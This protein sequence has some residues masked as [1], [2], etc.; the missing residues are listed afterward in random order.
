MG[1]AFEQA[2]VPDGS[3]ME[4]S[5]R[6]LLGEEDPRHVRGADDRVVDPRDSLGR[7]AAGELRTGLRR[8]R[9]E[10]DSAATRP[11]GT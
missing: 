4:H 2:P 11:V 8:I 1:Q 5:M 10:H 6:A 3:E 7:E 9:D